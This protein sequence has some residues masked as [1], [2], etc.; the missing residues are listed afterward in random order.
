MPH[1]RQPEKDGVE[2][3]PIRT[4]LGPPEVLRG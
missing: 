3:R 2:G 4:R 1:V